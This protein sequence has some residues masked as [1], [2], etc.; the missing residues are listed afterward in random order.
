DFLGRLAA[1]PAAAGALDRLLVL[2]PPEAE[3]L[4]EILRAP[5]DRLGYGYEDPDLVERMIRAIGGEPA[6]L[7]LLQFAA[8][9]LWEQRDR[10]RRL[11]TSAAYERIGGVEGAL[12]KHA[13]GVLAGL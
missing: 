6:R 13:D 9:L 8:A 3:A 5:L 4:R 12:A 11:L 10:E 7:P 2:Q 1:G